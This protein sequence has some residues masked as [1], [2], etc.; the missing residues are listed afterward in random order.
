MAEER[1]VASG[2][3]GSGGDLVRLKSLRIK[4]EQLQKDLNQYVKAL[5][6][7]VEGRHFDANGVLA[8]GRG[9]RQRL[10]EDLSSAAADIGATQLEAQVEEALRTARLYYREELEREL[11]RAGIARAG[12]WPTYVLGNLVHLS[13]D[14]D[15]GVATLDRK[16]LPTLEPGKITELVRTGLAKLLERS[17]TPEEFLSLLRAAYDQVTR[18]A[19]RALG[20]YAAIQDV[21]QSL[22]TTLK[23][24]GGDLRYSEAK[25]A[26]DLWKVMRERR[27]MTED[28]MILDLSPAQDAAQGIF[29][30]DQSGGNYMAAL[31][32]VPG[33]RDV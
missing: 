33:G 9:L 4:L 21:L 15:R 31:R 29:V 11:D 26:A 6:A 19:G 22:S 16:K 7:A 20:D 13:L 32:F 24:S 27:A 28:G 3:V 23:E 10:A 8:T 2:D 30:P 17:F 5:V 12:Q 25:L 1:E 14:L 18:Q